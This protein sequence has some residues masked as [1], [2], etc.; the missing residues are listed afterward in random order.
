MSGYFSG[1]RSRSFVEGAT[2]SSTVLQRYA[3]R[4]RMA[5]KPPCA[6]PG[7]GGTIP[8]DDGVNLGTVKLHGN[9]DMARFESLLFQALDGTGLVFQAMRNGPMKDKEPPGEPRIMRSLL[10][11]L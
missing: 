10:Q 5:V 4:A 1:M 6:A 11:A 8:V 3:C 2:C 9:I 7:K